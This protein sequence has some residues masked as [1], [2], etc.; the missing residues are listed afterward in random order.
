M[1]M[2][3]AA[4][5]LSVTL[6]QPPSV[7]SD[8]GTLTALRFS[9]TAAWDGGQMNAP[10]QSLGEGFS[11]DLPTGVPIDVEVDGGRGWHALLAR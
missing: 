9:L 10:A 3:C 2:A 6:L 7:S 8:A 1:T 5:P 4:R 11:L